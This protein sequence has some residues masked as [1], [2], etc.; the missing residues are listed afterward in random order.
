MLEFAFVLHNHQPLGQFERVTDDA[1]R[2]AYTP[3]LDRLAEH[4]SARAVLHFSGPL[5]L[6]LRARHRPLLARVAEL[7]LERRV[8]LLTSGFGEPILPAIPARDRAPQIRR[9][10]RLVEETFGVAPVGAWVTERVWDP[11]LVETCLEAG[12]RYVILDEEHL[13]KAGAPRGATAG[14]WRIL[15]DGGALLAFASDTLLRH[16][17]PFSPAEGVLQLLARRGPGER[18]LLVAADDGEKFG[19]WPGTHDLCYGAPGRRGWIDTFLLGLADLAGECRMVLLSD[20]LDRPPAGTLCVPPGSY[21]EMNQWAFGPNPPKTTG[22]LPPDD[23]PLLQPGLWHNFPRRY[24][25]AGTLYGKMRAVSAEAALVPD[26]HFRE[27][28]RDDLFLAQ[29]NCAYWHG[30]FGGVYLPHLRQALAG[31]LVSARKTLEW[32]FTEF[33]REIASGAPAY[34]AKKHLDWVRAAYFLD[35]YAEADLAD[36]LYTYE[37]AAMTPGRVVPPPPALAEADFDFDGDP[38]LSLRGPAADVYLDPLE[39]GALFSF[40]LKPINFDLGLCLTRL[41]EAYHRDYPGTLGEPPRPCPVPLDPFRRSTFRDHFLVSPDAA[42]LGRGIFREAGDFADGAYEVVAR[43]PAS[44]TLRREGRVAAPAGPL[45][46]LVEKRVSLDGLTVECAWSIRLD[47]PPP[48]V[49]FAPSVHLALLSTEH[50]R[51]VRR[52]D[53]ARSLAEACV[54]EGAAP[55]TLEDDW[56]GLSVAVECPEA[57]RLLHAPCHS[58]SRNFDKFESIYQGACLHPLVPLTPGETRATLRLAVTAVPSLPGG[59]PSV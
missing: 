33:A 13:L 32:Y 20:L 34:A 47:D 14:P 39:G 6:E 22:A 29:C 43:G 30:V 17:M 41:P 23:A 37:P 24:R 44:V 1:V 12:V 40:D 36:C 58:L 11:A 52:G 5:L 46:C 56:L 27:R 35:R 57:A 55:V 19:E 45:P 18:R 7:A 28:V 8:E 2:L 53:D 42:E 21:H 9:M 4:P 38:E 26:P 15:A 25:E 51:R 59:A 49:L 48:G 10:S 3:L 31:R 54:F 50:A 16:R